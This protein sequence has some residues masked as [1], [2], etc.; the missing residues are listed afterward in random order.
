MNDNRPRRAVAYLIP[1]PAVLPDL[2]NPCHCG[3]EDV[4]ADTEIDQG[5]GF[6]RHFVSCVRCG[7]EGPRTATEGT[8][9]VGWNQTT[10]ATAY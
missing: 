10:Q 9:T 6:R 7:A 4:F 2:P 5:T 8:A 1:S 3:S